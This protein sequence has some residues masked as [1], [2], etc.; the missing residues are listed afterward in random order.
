MAIADATAEPAADES[1]R[2]SVAVVTGAGRGI[3]RAVAIELS[4]RGNAVVVCARNKAEI[5]ETEAE[6]IASGGRCISIE[7]DVTRDGDVASLLEGTSQIFGHASVLVNNAGAFKGVSFAAAAMDDFQAMMELNFLS[8]VRVT[9]AFL[10]A[11]LEAQSGRII[12]IA[13]TAGKY[14]SRNQSM[15]NA[16]KH[17]VVGLT[18]CLALEFATSGVRINAVCPGFVNTALLADGKRELARLAGGSEHEVEES[19]LARVPIARILEP[20]EVAGLVGYL[21]SDA[22]DGITGQA[23]NVDGGLVLI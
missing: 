3:G 7:C 6:I 17:A 23:F 1:T 5:A 2:R 16:S 15:Y 4:R 8:V 20:Q 18:R 12:N 22:A 21:S 14:G 11:M 19:I 13:S 10:P 9:K